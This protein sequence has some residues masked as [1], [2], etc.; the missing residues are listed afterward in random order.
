MKKHRNKAARDELKR[1]NPILFEAVTKVMYSHD[2]MGI[3]FGVNP[4][5]YD[6]EASTVI[7]R[8][9]G[10]NSSNELVTILHEEF[11]YWFGIEAAG[12]LTRYSALAEDLWNIWQQN[13][14]QIYK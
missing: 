4:D 2:P 11:V 3:N 8:L 1:G 6:L 10:C 12:E 7:P 14:S 5:E 9:V 13:F